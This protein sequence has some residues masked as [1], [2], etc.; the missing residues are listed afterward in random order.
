MRMT[1][2]STTMSATTNGR[3]AAT[4]A[5]TEAELLERIAGPKSD[6]PKSQTVTIVPAL[7]ALG[8]YLLLLWV[9]ASTADSAREQGARRPPAGVP[10]VAH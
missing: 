6:A 1:T 3:A 8:L 10:A 5:V 7:V 9:I 2:M 4:A